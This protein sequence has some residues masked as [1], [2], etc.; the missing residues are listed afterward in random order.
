MIL[1]I[2][3]AHKKGNK[4]A[5]INVFTGKVEDMLKKYVVEPLRL[6]YQE[7]LASTEAST[8]ILRIDDVIA[9]KGG[10]S[11]GKSD[12]SYAGMDED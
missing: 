11:S 3:N 7:I 2:R 10:F 5:G 8:M 4:Y 9:S 1:E 6:G 12:H